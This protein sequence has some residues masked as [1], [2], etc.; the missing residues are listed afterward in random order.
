MKKYNLIKINKEDN[1]Y[2]RFDVIKRNR[3]KRHKYQEFFVEGVR[4]I[5]QAIKNNWEIK[6][7]LYSGEKLLSNWA[8]DLLNSITVEHVFELPQKLME[9]LSEKEDTSE[10][11]AIVAM[12]PDS[13]KRIKF[14][15]NPLII[16][17][18]RP[19]NK[20][21]LGTII[22]SCDAMGCD[23]LIIT[24]HSVDLYE[25]ETIISSTG[26]FFKLPTIRLQSPSEIAD[27]VL[28]MKTLYPDIQIVGTDECGEIRIDQCEFNKPTILLMGNET[29][30]LSRN[31]KQISDKMVKIPIGGSASSLNVACA[32]SILL[33]EI[34]RQ[35]NFKGIC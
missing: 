20:G 23:G 27:L 14:G 28:S 26:S 30:G 8:K 17:F 15:S 24:G 33:Y 10:L 31:Y 21:N 11:I 32:T 5:N 19:S 9:K 16:V 18:D 1:N 6:S 34:N 25:P 7:F 13:I 29:D 22:R 3:N 12:Q 35:R 2:Q 4:N